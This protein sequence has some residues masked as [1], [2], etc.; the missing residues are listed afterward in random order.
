MQNNNS[1]LRLLQR[2]KQVQSGCVKYLIFLTNNSPASIMRRYPVGQRKEIKRSFSHAFPHL[3]AGSQ[4]FRTSPWTVGFGAA[5][6]AASCLTLS[7]PFPFCEWDST[8]G[9]FLPAACLGM[10]RLLDHS[11]PPPSPH[12][13]SLLP[14]RGAHLQPLYYR[15][16]PSIVGPL[17][18]CHWWAPEM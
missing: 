5:S 15:P 1:S 7:L 13:F 9:P 14:G 3:A 8:C 16:A 17:L 12:P 11:P 18:R 6:A 4:W 10:P 2:W